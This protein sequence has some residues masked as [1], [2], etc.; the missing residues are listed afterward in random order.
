[1][2]NR[3]SKYA[4]LYVVNRSQIAYFCNMNWTHSPTKDVIIA[5]LT[6]RYF[7]SDNDDQLVNL[8]QNAKSNKSKFNF[9][10]ILS[11]KHIQRH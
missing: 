5:L 4:M 1:M 11:L 9:I 10:I 8:Q 7:I 3:C 2:L 6:S